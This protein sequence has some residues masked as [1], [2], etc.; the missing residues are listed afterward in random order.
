[1]NARALATAVAER[2]AAAGVPDARFEAEVL[3]RAA[4]RLGRAAY[5]AGATLEESSLR[6]LD[7]MVAR[8]LRREPTA[9]VVGHR[10][11]FGRDFLVTPATLVPRPETE[12]L[13]EFALEVIDAANRPLLL[14]DVGTGCGCIGV[15]VA[16]ERPRTRVV[17]VDISQEALVVAAQNARRHGALVELL[18]A[19]LL[20]PIA[21]ADIVV[22]NL[23]YIPTDELRQ[24]EPELREWE[25][26]VALDGGRTGTELIE[27][28]LYECAARCVSVV[29]VEVGYG[30]AQRV[31]ECARR[32]GAATEL[33]K[34]LAGIDR[35]V[36]A[37]WA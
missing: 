14:V 23:P 29:A 2:L 33:R 16:C 28:L 4:G 17:G 27:R 11:F 5:F 20:G 37:R 10:E 26:R 7:E 31:A 21:R 1:M 34:D 9:Y 3:V 12:L 6:R 35:V 22:A 15:S 36:I 18:V 30:Q 25:P 32:L 24:L 19:D 8:R 13:V